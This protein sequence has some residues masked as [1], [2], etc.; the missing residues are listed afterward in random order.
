MGAASSAELEAKRDARLGLVEVEDEVA[1][2]LRLEEHERLRDSMPAETNQPPDPSKI[3]QRRKKNKADVDE[4]SSEPNVFAIALLASKLLSKVAPEKLP[5]EEMPAI[6]AGPTAI[7]AGDAVLAWSEGEYHPA[8]VTAA[9]ANEE[10][11]ELDTV[12][13]HFEGWGD[14]ED[15]FEYGKPAEEVMRPD[16]HAEPA[17]DPEAVPPAEEV[18]KPPEV[19]EVDLGPAV[20]AETL[21]EKKKR[22]EAAKKQATQEEKERKAQ[23]AKEAKEKK[24]MDALAKKTEKE[25]KERVAKEAKAAKKMSQLVTE[26]NKAG[27][28]A[29]AKAAKE[30]K[31]AIKEMQK[32]DKKELEAHVKANRRDFAVAARTKVM[33]LVTETRALEATAEAAEADAGSEPK[34][35]DKQ[36]KT[37]AAKAARKAAK[38][39]KKE[40]EAAAKDATKAEQLADKEDAHECSSSSSSSSDEEEFKRS[41]SGGESD[42]S[43]R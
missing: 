17:T 40:T 11:G 36:A 26:K 21:K 39:K 32:S 7:T 16:A 29:A 27:K 6:E 1:F 20:A 15:A 10:T 19:E 12:D 34:G 5:V 43:W 2:C 33:M 18:E 28:E 42:G 8:V 35:P 24:S 23:A 31:K 37:E 25:E 38:E 14:G 9:Y 41:H 3:K 13:V 22:I 30:D 4:A